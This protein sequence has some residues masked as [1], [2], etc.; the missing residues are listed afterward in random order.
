MTMAMEEEVSVG[1]SY[2]GLKLHPS[3]GKLRVRMT[4]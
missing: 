2:F 4:N 1:S 3:F